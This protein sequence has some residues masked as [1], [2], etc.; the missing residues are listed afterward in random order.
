MSSVALAEGVFAELGV[1]TDEIAMITRS[2]VERDEQLLIEQQAFH[3]SEEKL[4]QSARDSAAEL[5]QLL[6]ND[7][8][9]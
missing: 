2:F 1:A 5:E 4:Q 6:R 9:R 3:H 7:A 8:Q